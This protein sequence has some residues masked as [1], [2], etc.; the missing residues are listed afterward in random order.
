[1]KTLAIKSL[2]NKG[3]V[4]FMFLLFSNFAC[5]KRTSQDVASVNN[6]TEKKAD[7]PLFQQ[8]IITYEDGT[9]MLYDLSDGQHL[10]E[11]RT[12]SDEDLNY[13]HG[14][15]DK[16]VF[17]LISSDKFRMVNVNG[18]RGEVEINSDGNDEWY[19]S[20]IY[21]N[22]SESSVNLLFEGEYEWKA[23]PA[24]S[25]ITVVNP[26]DQELN[27]EDM[28]NVFNF[29]EINPNIMAETCQGKELQLLDKKTDDPNDYIYETWGRGIE[30]KSWLFTMT[31]DDA[32]AIHFLK[33]K[34]EYIE[35]RIIFSN[36]KLIP[37]Y[38][39]QLSQHGYFKKRTRVVE[40]MTETTYA[41][42]D[43][44]PGSDDSTYTLT[45]DGQGLFHL[46][47]NI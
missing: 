22:L 27:V 25:K 3:W 31:A 12:Y 9:K 4:L 21:S 34:S 19:S 46:V 14:A 42:D 33:K 38:E 10:V 7:N 1:M 17:Y 39:K 37:A 6:L 41:S 35:V 30:A 11:A 47:F 5:A 15:F 28:V 44:T 2:V 26:N 40:G 13:F 18:N 29:H 45:D 8:W 43:W 24:T 20:F 36:P 32:L 16:D 23:E